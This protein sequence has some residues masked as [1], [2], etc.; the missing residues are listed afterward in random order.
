MVEMEQNDDL[1]RINKLPQKDTMTKQ[2][3][4]RSAKKYTLHRIGGQ[5]MKSYGLHYV[6][7]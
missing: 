5:V 4:R 2:T 1:D 7:C 6:V 3:N